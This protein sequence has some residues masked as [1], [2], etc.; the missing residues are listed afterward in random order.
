MTIDTKQMGEC[1]LMRFEN[2]ANNVGIHLSDKDCQIIM[3]CYKVKPDDNNCLDI[4]YEG[5]IKS[6]VPI[7]QKNNDQYLV[8]RH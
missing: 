8:N 5:A 2:E 1:S 3:Q 7:I 6:I 4:N